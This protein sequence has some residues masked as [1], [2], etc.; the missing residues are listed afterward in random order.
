STGYYYVLP[1][2]VYLLTYLCVAI[3]TSAFAAS[4]F[5]FERLSPPLDLLSPY[6]QS[7]A[8][9]NSKTTII[10]RVTF[11]FP[12]LNFATINP[13]LDNGSSIPRVFTSSYL[14]TVHGSCLVR[15]PSAAR[16]ATVLNP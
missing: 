16:L 7:S 4:D 6:F 15:T 5:Y 3:L 2:S 1:A 8:S 13:Y 10:T 11:S 9:Y 12:S 14:F